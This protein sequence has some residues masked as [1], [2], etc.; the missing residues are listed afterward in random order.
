LLRTIGER[1][2][3]AQ[4]QL[5][6]LIHAAVERQI[7]VAELTTAIR[8]LPQEER[9]MVYSTIRRKQRERAPRLVV[10]QKHRIVAG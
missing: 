1:F 10:V 5:D 2:R 6:A 3:M 9:E 8:A 4:S 7:T